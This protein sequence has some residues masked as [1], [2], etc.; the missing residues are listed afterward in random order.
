MV[1]LFINNKYVAARAMPVLS[2]RV[3]RLEDGCRRVWTISKSRRR[4]WSAMRF[5]SKKETFL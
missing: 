5:C 1:L 2:A 3:A 4:Y